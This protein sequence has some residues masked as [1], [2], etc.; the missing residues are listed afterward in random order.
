MKELNGKTFKVKTEGPFN[1]KIN[2]DT[3]KFGKYISEGIIT[4]VKMPVKVKFKTL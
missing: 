4:K 3:R 2:C 1:F